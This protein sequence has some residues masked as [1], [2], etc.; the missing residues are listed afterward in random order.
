[1]KKQKQKTNELMT[2][3]FR[4]QFVIY[5]PMITLIKE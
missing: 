3:F 2:Y 1:M 4:M 5:K